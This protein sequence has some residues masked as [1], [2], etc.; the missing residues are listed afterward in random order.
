[1]KLLCLVFFLLVSATVKG[2]DSLFTVTGF[3][4][5][6]FAYDLNNP[7]DRN[8]SFTTQPARHNEFNLNWGFIK[9]QYTAEKVRSTVALQTG[10]FVAVNYAAEND[11]LR[12]VYQANVGYKIS[13][14]T[15]IDIG[16]MPSHIGVESM[17]SIDNWNYGRNLTSDFSP[18]YQSGIHISSEVSTKLSLVFAILNG[19][20]NIRETNNSKSVGLMVNWKPAESVEIGYSNY[21]GDEAPSD[22]VF[23]GGVAVKLTQRYRLFND[24]F[25][26]LKL[27][28]RLGAIVIAEYSA[29]Q[30]FETKQ[31]NPWYA[32]VAMSEYRITNDV[33]VALRLEKFNDRHQNVAVTNTKNGFQVNNA[34]ATFTFRPAHNVAIRLEG[35]YFKSKDTIYLNGNNKP[36]S[37]STVISLSTAMKF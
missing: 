11:L 12:L 27:S 28:K 1:M 37:I 15:W 29:Q 35:R 24:L 4:D 30:H 9:A 23:I 17:L 10:T 36:T 20:Q 25:L 2:Q 8:R 3:L 31:W 33:Q 14:R 32:F 16:I 7:A 18:Y 21:F 19:F 34:T 5:V 26:R 6:Y 13:K 22:S